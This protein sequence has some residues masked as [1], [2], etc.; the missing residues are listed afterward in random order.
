[1]VLTCFDRAALR[2]IME[3]AKVYRTD[4]SFVPGK[5]QKP[6]SSN[7]PFGD[8][9]REAVYADEIPPF[10]ITLYGKNEFGNQM[11]MR[12]FG[13]TLISEGSG[14]SIDDGIQEAQYTYVAKQLSSWKPVEGTAA[15]AANT[16]GYTSESQII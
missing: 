12:I 2:D 3:L 6:T 4:Q 5:A 13:V 8:T 14:F 11:V 7:N 1:M 15:S 9:Y 16:T 10:D